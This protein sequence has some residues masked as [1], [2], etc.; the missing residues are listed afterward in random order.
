MSERS[1]TSHRRR[2]QEMPP[3]R[4]MAAAQQ[5]NTPPVSQPIAPPRGY[6]QQGQPVQGG[7]PAGYAVGPMGQP[8]PGQAM[9]VN[10]P[11]PVTNWQTAPSQPV[12]P[13][14]GHAPAP[15][16]GGYIPPAA[17]RSAAPVRTDRPAVPSPH[18]GDLNGYVPPAPPG[19]PPKKGRGFWK[20]LIVLLLIAVA[21]VIGV[22]IVNSAQR[23]AEY[24]KT[25]AYVTSYDNVFCPNVWV[26]GI[27]LGG[28][29]Y[30]D[31]FAAV[32][33][34]AQQRSSTWYVNLT[35]QGQ[36]VTTITAANLGMRVDVESVLAEAWMQGHMSEDP[37]ERK[38]AMDVLLEHPYAGYTAMPS[39]NTAVIDNLLDELQ[40]RIYIEPQDARLISFDA[41]LSYPFV[42]QEEVVG[43]SLNTAELK[44]RLYTMVSTME[45]GDVELVPDVTYPTVTVANLKASLA[46]RASVYT[47][48]SASST[49]NRNNNIR[50]C[51]E[52]ITGTVLQPGATF[53]FNNVVG[54]RTTAN[55]FYS[56]I[57]YA[58]GE[59]VEGIGG[60][61]CQASTTLYQAAVLSG[62]TVTAREP[63]SDA[64]KYAAYGQDATVYWEGK[65]KIDL[66]F[67]NSTDSPIYI[68]AAVQP[69]PSNRKRYIARVTIYGED[70]GNVRYELVTE[71]VKVLKPPTE[72]EYKKDTKGTYVTYTD[73]QHVAR[74]AKDGV[75]V[76]SYRVKYENDVE[77]ERK[78]LFTDTYEAKS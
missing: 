62:L 33:A 56:A 11:R 69:D 52:K 70:M 59:E 17:H 3:E 60:G 67:R 24:N 21:A 36:V 77:V 48:I 65:R 32:T 45:S 19:E 8:Y 27:H 41:S 51:F 31:A 29:T 63:H 2:A 76:Q 20:L 22:V 47:P 26:D 42:F 68:V 38:A 49:E 40:T 54:K 30:D 46:M 14:Q 37:L 7:Y 75:V 73:Q 58:Y 15:L 50:R 13:L 16:T 71:E 78:P 4:V 34:Q 1:G 10:Q 44:S 9:P 64:V 57:E 39:G 28:M 53:S 12:N 43:R 55:G 74:K 23:T 25:K 6:P 5:W 35:Y 66:V 72:P 61:T 18:R